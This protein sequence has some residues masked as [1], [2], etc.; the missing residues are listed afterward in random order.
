[1]L[2]HSKLEGYVNTNRIAILCLGLHGPNPLLI[3]AGRLSHREIVSG[4]HTVS[5]ETESLYHDSK[6]LPN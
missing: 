1:M 2:E 4:P 6:V 3:E 5:V